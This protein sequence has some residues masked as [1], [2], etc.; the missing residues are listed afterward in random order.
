MKKTHIIIAAAALFMLA[1]SGCGNESGDASK[2]A[3]SSSTESTASSSS[4]S[5]QAA[6]SSSS[7]KETAE[8]SSDSKETSA[9]SK[10]GQST[11][12]DYQ[13]DILPVVSG[14]YTYEDCMKLGKYK[15]IELKKTVKEIKDE[16]VDAYLKSMAESVTVDD[17]NA[18]AQNGDTVNI[19]YVGEIDGKPFDGGS[20]DGYDL[21]LGSGSFIKGFEDGV[22][23]MKVGEKKDLNLKFPDVYKDAGVAGKDVVFHVTLNGIKRMPEMND[24]WVKANYEG[25]FETLQELKDYTREYLHTNAESAADQTLRQNAWTQVFG[26]TEFYQLPEEMVKEG[27][28][29]YDSQLN[30][31]TKQYGMTRE[32][33]L[34]SA[35]LDEE[36]Y[37][38]EREQFSQGLAKS[39]LI[40]SAIWDNEGMTEDAEYDGIIEDIAS[41]YGM[42]AEEFM[43]QQ[44]PKAVEQYARTQKILNFIVD[45]AIVTEVVE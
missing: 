10:E 40:Y 18:T 11:G 37:E 21:V 39:L 12:E 38:K 19:A 30:T 7:S 42:S 36:T 1:V 32:E 14:E 45:N 29:Q 44:D 27:E 35:G 4:S 17:P 15:G 43:E 3:S 6:S 26:D 25:Q 13:A 2:A 9:S 33:Y 8:Q 24:D 5:E 34:E 41:A 22:V 20:S 31:I 28:A 23:G 16:D